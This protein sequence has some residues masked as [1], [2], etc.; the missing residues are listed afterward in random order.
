MDFQL[1]VPFPVLPFLGFQSGNS[2]FLNQE[3]LFRVVKYRF[4]GHRDSLI[5]VN[6]V[7][8][9]E[10]RTKLTVIV[11]LQIMNSDIEPDIFMKHTLQQN[12][13]QSVTN[14]QLL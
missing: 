7:N 8:V 6:D 4:Y 14:I 5:T 11:S 2:G 3:S 13:L 1:N 10:S 9:T 12:S